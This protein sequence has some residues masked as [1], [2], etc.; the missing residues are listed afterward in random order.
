MR[1]K[2][3]PYDEL[4]ALIVRNEKPQVKM[5]G[6]STGTGTDIINQVDSWTNPMTTKGDLIVGGETGGA[7]RQGIGTEDQVLTVVDVGGD[8]VPRWANATGGSSTINVEEGGGLVSAADT[9]N[10]DDV[11]FDV[12]ESPAGTANVTLQVPGVTTDVLYNESGDLQAS[13]IGFKFTDGTNET[14]THLDITG[15]INVSHDVVI[16]DTL[17][18]STIESPSLPLNIVL[19]D[20]LQ[21]NADGGTAGQMLQSN[22]TGNPPTW[23]DA[24]TGGGS[25]TD[26]QVRDVIG[27]ALVAGNN[28]D[29]TVNDGADTITID[30]ESLTSADI[31]DFA[32]AVDERARDA[33]GTALVAGNNIDITV[34]DGADTI[35]IDVESLTST[36]ITDFSEAVDD[37]VSALIVAGNN[38]DV[39]YNDGANTLTIDVESLTSGDITDFTEAAQDA[40]GA[41][42]T[43]SSSI[44][45]TYND[46]ANTITANV[47]DEY[48]EDTVAAMLLD[49]TNIDF[50]YNDASDQIT[51]ELTLAAR[52]FIV[53]YMIDG[54]GS[55]ITTGLKGG[56]KMIGC[57]ITAWEIGAVDGNTGAIVVD[58][59]SDSYANFPPTNSDSFTGSEKP[60][61]TATGSK[62]QDTSLNSGSGWAITNGNWIFFNVDSVT[63]LTRV[64]LALTCVR[65]T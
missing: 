18:V 56:I 34:N 1:D 58:M 5:T 23:E 49:S 15:S 48:V 35:T 30:V 20:E 52:T 3:R 13:A 65:P 8:L 61:I 16:D 12:G 55:V 19:S 38:I 22:G 26:E 6:S 63:T 24:P 50:T 47:F 44:D 43:S 60:T 29:I 2:R 28:I 59:W 41:T 62:G 33:V 7:V 53:N 17:E 4:A 46:V 27:A 39:T 9:I 32:T 54:G 25:Y 40:V 42:L 51:A 11:D 57:T 37:R 45:L 10:F 36:D 64:N 14:D 21:F 31:T